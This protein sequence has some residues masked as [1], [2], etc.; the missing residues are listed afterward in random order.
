MFIDL[1]E[2]KADAI[3]VNNEKIEDL[4]KG[5]ESIEKVKFEEI[6]L[7]SESIPTTNMQLNKEDKKEVKEDK[8]KLQEKPDKA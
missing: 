8:E 4:N 2:A 5:I 6:E 3:R 7:V 1:E